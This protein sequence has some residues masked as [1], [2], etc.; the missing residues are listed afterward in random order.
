MMAYK[1]QHWSNCRTE[2]TLWAYYI[3]LDIQYCTQP[4]NGKWFNGELDYNLDL[5]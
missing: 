2:S 3:T 1:P 5:C 4:E